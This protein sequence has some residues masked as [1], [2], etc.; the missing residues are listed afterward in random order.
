M[1]DE[2]VSTTVG[3]LAFP[4]AVRRYAILVHC[5]PTYKRCYLNRRGSFDQSI[6]RPPAPATAAAAPLLE[7]PCTTTSQWLWGRCLSGAAW[8]LAVSARAAADGF[9]LGS[10]SYYCAP[11]RPRINLKERAVSTSTRPNTSERDTRGD[12]PIGAWKSKHKT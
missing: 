9:G 11:R 12:A 4:S 1:F 8:W 10:L 5:R 7:Y 3:V 6:A 2:P